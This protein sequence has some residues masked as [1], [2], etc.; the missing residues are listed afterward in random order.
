M[1]HKT[2]PTVVI[3]DSGI[4]TS[5]LFQNQCYNILEDKVAH[6][7][8]MGENF[9]WKDAL[10]FHDLEKSNKWSTQLAILLG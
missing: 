6:I 9:T 7:M 5:K 10:G 1:K 4:D 8:L 2:N 3:I